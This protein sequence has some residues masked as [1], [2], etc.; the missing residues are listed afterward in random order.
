MV[1]QRQRARALFIP[2][3]WRCSFLCLRHFIFP[4][5]ACAFISEDTESERDR[6]ALRTVASSARSLSPAAALWR[7]TIIARCRERF[8]KRHI[9]DFTR[10]HGRLSAG[11]LWD[12]SVPPLF[13]LRREMGWMKMTEHCV[14][15]G[16]FAH[17]VPHIVYV[18]C[19]MRRRR[20][21]EKLFAPRCRV[22]VFPCAKTKSVCLPYIWPLLI[23]TDNIC[24]RMDG[25]RSLSFCTFKVSQALKSQRS[26]TTFSIQSRGIASR[27]AAVTRLFFT[28]LRV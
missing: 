25:G 3:D 14:D 13:C 28:H 8:I 20:R 5:A 2:T 4:L 9:N 11:F 26:G 16:E 1:S 21:K 23:I 19:K 12:Y 10:H 7:P 22:A 17:P 6:P 15:G 24:N 18:V 27:G